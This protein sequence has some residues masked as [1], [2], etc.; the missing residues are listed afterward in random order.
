MYRRLII[1]T[2]IVVAGRVRAGGPGI[3]RHR[4]MVAGP[5]GDTAGRIRRG[6]RADPPGR[7]TKARRVHAGR[8]AAQV[9]RLP[10]FLRAG[11][12]R[13]RRAV[14][15]AAVPAGR[16]VVELLRLRLFPD[17]AGR[18]YRHPLLS[19]RP[20]RRHAGRNGPGGAALRVERR[21]KMCCLRSRC[22]RAL[23]LPS[24]EPELAKDSQA[25]PPVPVAKENAAPQV[26]AGKK[27]LA[28]NRYGRRGDYPIESLNQE[29]QE[30]QVYRQQRSIAYSNQ[31]QMAQAP[32]QQSFKME[33]EPDQARQNAV[34]STVPAPVEQVEGAAT[35]DLASQ[36]QGGQARIGCTRA[37][38]PLRLRHRANPHRA[39]RAAGRSRSETPETSIFGGQV[40]LLAAR[41]DRETGTCSRA[42][43]W[44]SRD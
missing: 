18:E 21:G 36:A 24:R 16:S 10:L 30:T 20:P 6:G 8:A 40:F 9:H 7:Q 23:E 14:A 2:A 42:F 17:R 44:M 31:A 39:V 26:P 35:A 41:A 19:G 32:S 22:G 28:D 1:L 38:E 15:A 27:G 4:E 34:S 5:G 33:Q 3:S 43:S 37:S 11:K 13:G 25:T 29:A 12:H